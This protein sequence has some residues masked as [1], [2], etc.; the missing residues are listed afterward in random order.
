M[1]RI[2]GTALAFV[3]AVVIAHSALCVHPI[4]FS[5][6]SVTHTVSQACCVALEGGICGICVGAV[7]GLRR[8]EHPLG[9]DHCCRGVSQGV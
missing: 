2:Q 5:G 3:T 1:H 4:E 7:A 8:E 9:R 6:T